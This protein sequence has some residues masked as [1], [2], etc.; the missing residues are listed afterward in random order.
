VGIRKTVSGNGNSTA[1][2]ISFVGMQDHHKINHKIK[3]DP[4]S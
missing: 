3:E 4:I 1:L 2:G